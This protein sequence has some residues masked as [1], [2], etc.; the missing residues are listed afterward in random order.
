VGLQAGP[1][2]ASADEFR[3]QIQ[4]DGGHAA[5]PHLAVDPIAIGAEVVGALQ[6]IVARNTN[7]F[8]TLVLSVTMFH[9][10]TAEN[11][12]PPIADMVGTVRAFRPE[13][14][15]EAERLID[16]VIRG[17][18]EA[19]GAKYTFHYDYGY[20]PVV[21]DEG[22]TRVVRAAL[23]EALGEGAVVA[24]EP[25]MGAEDFSAY[26][27]EAPGAFFFIGAG[28][29]QK[30]MV[31]QH[32]HGQFMIDED[33]LGIGVQGMVEAAGAMLTSDRPG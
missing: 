26:Q 24:N 8:D 7:P 2:Q 20:D 10:G 12:I 31:R 1:V 22:A 28:N 21:N 19:H 32:H 13:M 18:T 11:V 6:Q 16:R 25:T 23:I 14:R 5:Y 17:V 3:I 15:R 30:G 4:G 9:A 33:C 27:K 29:K